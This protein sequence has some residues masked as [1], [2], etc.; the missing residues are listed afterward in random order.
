MSDQPPDRR[1]GDRRKALSAY[2]GATN[3]ETEDQAQRLTCAFC[4]LYADD[5]EFL[6]T[7]PKV[8]ICDDCVRCCVDILKD[9]S[10]RRAEGRLDKN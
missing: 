4:G 9:E 6:I 3:T 10:D 2:A 1:A 5:V 7:G 8:S